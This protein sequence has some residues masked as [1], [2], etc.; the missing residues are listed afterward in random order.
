MDVAAL[1]LARMLLAVVFVVAA[2][3][4]LADREGS[5]RGA[6]DF[7]VPTALAALVALAELAVAAALIPASST[8]W[9]AVGRSR[10]WSFSRQASLPTLP[11]AASQSAI[12]WGSCTRRRPAGRR[13]CATVGWPP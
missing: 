6:A 3:A 2:G 9:G 12:A 7:G 4:K 1:L 5:R 11:V 13:L 8:W 10:S